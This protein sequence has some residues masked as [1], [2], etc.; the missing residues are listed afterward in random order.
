MDRRQYIG[1]DLH[2]DNF[3]TSFLKNEE[4]VHSQKY[5]LSPKGF[6][7]FKSKL[8]K[9]DKI[10]VEATSNSSYF[11]D[12]IYGY[13]DAITVVAPGE[14]SV[15]GHSTKKT[16]LNDAQ[17]LAFFLSKNMLPKA[18]LKSFLSQQLLSMITTRELLVK[19]RTAL[20]HKTCNILTRFGIKLTSGRL[21]WSNSYDKYVFCHKW[22]E[23]VEFE[24]RT[25]AKQVQNLN[26]E[27][28]SFNNIIEEY[29]SE[30]YG[31]EN[32]LS[33]NGIG[34][35]SAVIILS[36]IDN[37]NDF[38]CPS[39]L[40]SFFG[41]VPKIRHSN[42]NLKIGRITRKGSKLGRKTLIACTWQSIRYNEYLRKYYERV[43]AR[44][45]SKTAV[46]ATSRKL[47]KIIY[48]VLKNDWVFENFNMYQ[49]RKR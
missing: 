37:I 42:K 16:D 11:Y 27:I 17:K 22:E 36:T 10:A 8:S 23:M 34:S 49:Y 6:K 26:N 5:D 48:D 30:L 38:S 3:V 35:L 4:F 43:K 21:I 9:R 25:I 2:T 24:L 32:I 39:K 47:L 14:F 45:N 12:Q 15:I 29:G 40:S 18:R 31:Y 20:N 13:V 1:V 41:V 7:L 33:I 28:K 46:V 19:S 44:S